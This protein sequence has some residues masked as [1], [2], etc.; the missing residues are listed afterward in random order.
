MIHEY[1]ALCILCCA[2]CLIFIALSIW[3]GWRRDRRMERLITQYR[4]EELPR[5]EYGNDASRTC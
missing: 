2:I 5:K 3:A 1:I 4:A